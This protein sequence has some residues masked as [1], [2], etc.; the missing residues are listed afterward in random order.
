MNIDFRHRSV[1]GVSPRLSKNTFVSLL[2]QFAVTMKL[3]G[4]E[5]CAAL[6]EHCDASS[7]LLRGYCEADGRGVEMTSCSGS[8][9]AE[10][11]GAGIHSAGG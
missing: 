9:Q 4:V 6:V 3:N 10:I 8:T 5:V 1:P 7:E 11:P 2:D